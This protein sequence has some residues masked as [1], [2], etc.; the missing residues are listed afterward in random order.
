[1]AAGPAT[2][3]AS[4]AVRTV[5]PRAAASARFR[6][7]PRDV[8]RAADRAFV[9]DGEKTSHALESAPTGVTASVSDARR[10]APPARD[11]LAAATA[12][13]GALAEVRAHPKQDVG[14][15][16][17]PGSDPTTAGA[18]AELVTDGSVATS[19]SGIAGAGMSSL[20]D[21]GLTIVSGPAGARK[22]GTAAAGLASEATSGVRERGRAAATGAADHRTLAA[23]I[24]AEV[25][26]GEAGRVL[27]HAEK[28]EGSRID[29][30]LDADVA[31]TA[32]TL[33]ENAHDLA[34]D[35]RSDAR[36]TVNGPGTHASVSS[37]GSDGGRNST[38]SR[39]SGGDSASSRQDGE[40]R[41]PR[42]P[43]AQGSGTS[44]RDTAAGGSRRARFVL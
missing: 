41:D 32:R 5:D 40:N 19:P 39:G 24:H 20:S 8:A 14:S 26:L 3:L 9:A 15:D 42:A 4:A 16:A 18:A 30:R 44:D 37:S 12:P 2:E 25:D 36:V 34:L 31:R 10:E 27:V 13:E 1:V 38:S 29:V 6:I 35:L 28:T 22:A 11:P 17:K 21:G 43:H 7:T 33:S 23:G